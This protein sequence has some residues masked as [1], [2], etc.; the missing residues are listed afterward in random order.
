MHLRANT[1]K[2]AIVKLNAEDLPAAGMWKRGAELS[3]AL[4]L[5][6][7]QERRRCEAATR[8]ASSGAQRPMPSLWPPTW[9]GTF[10]Y[11]F[12]RITNPGADSYSVRVSWAINFGPLGSTESFT[13]KTVSR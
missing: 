11:S 10:A 7:L 13:L 6:P 5:G 8:S 1:Q 9:D 12:G 3:H 2:D 4:L